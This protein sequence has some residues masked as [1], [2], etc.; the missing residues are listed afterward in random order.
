MAN[1]VAK[2]T[3]NFF[4]KYGEAATQRNIIGRLLKF[5]KFGEFRAGQDEQEI[6]RGTALIAYM[7]TLAIGYVR[8]QDA[9][10]AEI[11]MGPVG[12][13]FVPPRREELGHTDQSYWET[14]DD[15]RPRDP[16]QL[17]NSLVLLDTES[18]EFY[19]FNSSSKGGLG[20]VG[21]LAKVYG[22]HLRQKPDEMPAIELDVGSYQHPNRAY[23]EIRFPILR[24]TG[25]IAA[26][27]LPPID[28]A[29]G[30]P[31]ANEP[32]IALPE[33]APAAPAKKP[34]TRPAATRL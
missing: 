15:G 28:G 11:I 25:W 31:A 19:T 29:P 30:E 3:Q 34:A 32:P 33:P 13:G 16:W 27:K 10:P 12:E 4:E 14:F 6:P 26:D 1:E 8:W 7:N 2:A 24:V 21:E 20:A 18:G 22:K 5:N 17:S 23:G 9:R